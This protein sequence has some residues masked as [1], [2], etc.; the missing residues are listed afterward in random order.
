MNIFSKKRQ[1]GKTSGSYDLQEKSVS[2]EETIRTE[3]KRSFE[4]SQVTNNFGDKV[5]IWDQNV[6]EIYILF[7]MVGSHE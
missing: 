3:S 2:A 1:H 7:K 4:K 6:R 5:S